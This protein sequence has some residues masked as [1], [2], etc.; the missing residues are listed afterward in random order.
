MVPKSMGK[1]YAICRR[2]D[3]GWTT[4]PESTGKRLGGD[5]L[6]VAR[7]GTRTIDL[8]AGVWILLV[9]LRRQ[10]QQRLDLRRRLALG[11]RLVLKLTGEIGQ[12]GIAG[13]RQLGALTLQ[14]SEDRHRLEQPLDQGVAGPLAAG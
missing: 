1:T 10:R 14:L 5:G 3:R 13:V 6:G 8:L 12:R 2:V 7:A 4:P 11:P 9:A